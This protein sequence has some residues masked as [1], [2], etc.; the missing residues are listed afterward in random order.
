MGG[1]PWTKEEDQLLRKCIEQHGEGK[2]H[3]LPLL[4]GICLLDFITFAIN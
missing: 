1:I 3:R 2:W 4:A